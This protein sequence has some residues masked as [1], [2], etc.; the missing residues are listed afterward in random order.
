MID[1][2]YTISFYPRIHSLFPSKIQFLY[3]LLSSISL[4]FGLKL[5]GKCISNN[6]SD[7]RSIAC[8]S[9]V[10]SYSCIEFYCEIRRK[11]DHCSR[12]KLKRLCF[13]TEFKIDILLPFTGCRKVQRKMPDNVHNDYIICTLQQQVLYCL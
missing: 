4:N 11:V 9:F 13:I 1:V 7:C 12:V 3:C 10:W 5:A 6:F 2:L 8:T